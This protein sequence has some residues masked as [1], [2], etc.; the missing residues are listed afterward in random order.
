MLDHQLFQKLK[1]LERQ[2][3]NVYQALQTWKR[4]WYSFFLSFKSTSQWY[5]FFSISMTLWVIL[6][7]KILH[8][9]ISIILSSIEVAL[10]TMMNIKNNKIRSDMVTVDGRVDENWL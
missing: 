9:N 4:N 3:Q 2:S 7:T 5:H 1:L 6:T 8:Y 10:T